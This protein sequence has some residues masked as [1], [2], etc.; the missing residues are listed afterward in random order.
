MSH[1]PIAYTYEADHHCPECAEARFGRCACGQV[2]CW[3][4]RDECGDTKPAQDSEG[5]DVGAVAPWDECLC[6][7]TCGTCGEEITP[8]PDLEP[9]ESCS[10]CGM[11]EGEEASRD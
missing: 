10:E 5:N 8:H 3:G 2:A 7:M 11:N 4:D 9:G 6:G 1:Q